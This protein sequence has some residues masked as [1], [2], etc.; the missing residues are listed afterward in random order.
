MICRCCIFDK[1]CD[2]ARIRLQSKITQSVPC[3]IPYRHHRVRTLN[4]NRALKR[5]LLI[6]I[7]DHVSFGRKQYDIRS[8]DKGISN[9][10]SLA[11]HRCILPERTPILLVEIS[12]TIFKD[13]EQIIQ[14]VAICIQ[15]QKTREIIAIETCNHL[16]YR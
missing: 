10:L 13:K 2:L 16:S 5:S 14:G 9:P 15:R 7:A 4:S 3:Q 11:K 6:G 1:R 12:I 8:V